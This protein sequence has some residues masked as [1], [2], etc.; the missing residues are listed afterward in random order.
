MPRSG[1]G[2]SALQELTEVDLVH[3]R[4]HFPEGRLPGKEHGVLLVGGELP[5][6]LE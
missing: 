3:M 1:N 4:K 2:Y 5:A 6:S